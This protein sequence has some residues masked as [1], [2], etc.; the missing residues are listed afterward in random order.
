[1]LTSPD[2]RIKLA[3][4]VAYYHC[5]TLDSADIRRQLYEVVNGLNEIGINVVSYVC[6]GASDML[7]NTVYR[8]H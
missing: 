6:H 4:P 1:M 7:I 8:C 3:F 2:P 5:V